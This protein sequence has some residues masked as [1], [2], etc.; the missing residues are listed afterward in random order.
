MVAFDARGSLPCDRGA[1]IQEC[2]EGAGASSLSAPTYLTSVRVDG[3]SPALVELD[4]LHPAPS[5]VVQ[6]PAATLQAALTALAEK[7]AQIK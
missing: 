2:G 7:V 3:H 1:S 6:L 4:D 5:I